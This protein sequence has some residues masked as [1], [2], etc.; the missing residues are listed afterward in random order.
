MKD[1]G[2]EPVSSYNQYWE[3]RGRTFED[4][5]GYRVALQNAAWSE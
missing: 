4:P 3:V 5:D 1:A 2:Y